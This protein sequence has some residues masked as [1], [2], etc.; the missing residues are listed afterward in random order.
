M[1]SIILPQYY[2]VQ[3][4][5]II[6]NIFMLTSNLLTILGKYVLPFDLL[7]LLIVMQ[8]P[9]GKLLEKRVSVETRTETR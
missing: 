3:A 5:Y 4:E 8:L 9:N 2:G 7:H 1:Y 6:V